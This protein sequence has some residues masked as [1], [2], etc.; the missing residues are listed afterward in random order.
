MEQKM[1]QYTGTKTLMAMPMGKEEAEKELGRT[2]KLVGEGYSGEGYLVEY[3]DGY[4][5]WSPKE[6]FEWTYSPSGTPMERMKIEI[7]ELQERIEKLDRFIYSESF[8]LI[9]KRSR[10]LLVAQL[11]NMEAYFQTLT[12]RY[13]I[14]DGQTTS[15]RIGFVDF[16]TA[17]N[18]LIAGMAVRR[19]TWRESGLV[20]IKQMPARIGRDIVPNMQSL[21]DNAKDMI[22]SGCGHINY[23]DQCLIYDT[24]TGRADSWA[25]SIQDIFAVDWEEVTTG[26]QDK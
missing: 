19:E 7:S 23:R 11:K 1:K 9:E 21:S 18:M 16:S 20:V 5:S 15:N 24:K 22:L 2:I 25:P 26:G 8:N 3:E 12:A 17:I 6:V 13:D 14:M 10:Y 4:R